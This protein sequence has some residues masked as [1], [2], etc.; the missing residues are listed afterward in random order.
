MAETA[1]AQD[2]WSVVR[3]TQRPE[4]KGW[5]LWIWETLKG[6]FQ[7]DRS[8]GQV[9]ADMVISL[10]PGVGTAASLRDLVANLIKF[11]SNPKDKLLLLF[12]ALALIGLIPEA[13]AVV[14]GVVRIL[15]VYLRRFVKDAAELSNATKLAQATSRA[16]DAALPKIVE[17]LRNSALVRWATDNRVPNLIRFAGTELIKLADKIDAAKLK[18]LF[19]QATTQLETLLKSI[20][21]MVPARAATQIE[22]FLA[23]LNKVR[24]QARNGLQTALQPLKTVL[25]TA[26]KRL[27]D[28]A[29][30]VDS[31]TVN[32]GWIAPMSQD[33]AAILIEKKPPKWVKKT[34]KRLPHPAPTSDELGAEV[35]NV[36]RTKE[37]ARKQG[38]MLPELSPGQVET[39]EKGKIAPT[40]I[41]GPA[42]LYR[43]VDPTSGGG[44]TFWVSEETFQQLKTRADWREKLAVRPDWNQNGQYVVYELK[45]G[46]T[47]HAWKGPAASQK[48]PG[49]SYHVAGGGE[50]IVF[51]PQ[52]DSFK[53]TLPNV[54]PQTGEPITMGGRVD[55][56]VN[57]ED[58]LG[59]PVR[60]GLR[61][62]INDPHIK[63]PFPTNWGFGDWTPDEAARIVVEIPKH[64]DKP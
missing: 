61:D 33:G 39:F 51:F 6:D 63:G 17:F 14:K 20:H 22:D 35:A 15:F 32:R 59:N 28:H 18:T 24:H 58:I 53:K 7:E 25:M 52:G 46:E 50:Q 26:G 19:D 12:I 37:S 29:L 64:L 36:Q 41:R 16:V 5:G 55:T 42:K 27:E 31:R 60:T 8:I 49:T 3:G 1:T 11:H 23:M 4:D 48:I 21:G 9:G 43:I 47:L 13:G 30:T 34:G 62:K 38:Q 54:D 40:T 56:R 45:P 10:I 44:G 57:F 2:A